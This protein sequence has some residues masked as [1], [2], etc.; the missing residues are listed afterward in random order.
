MSSSVVL[1]VLVL[2]GV[3]VGLT[4]R[5]SGSNSTGKGKAA[6]TPR[7]TSWGHAKF[8]NEVALPRPWWPQLD[9]IGI[10]LF[11]VKS[12]NPEALMGTSVSIYLDMR[13]LDEFDDLYG[14]DFNG[15]MT[16]K[17]DNGYSRLEMKPKYQRAKDKYGL[18]CRW[19]ATRKPTRGFETRKD[20]Y[21]MRLDVFA[22]TCP[23]PWDRPK[24]D[25]YFISWAFIRNRV[26]KGMTP[27]EI[28]VDVET[29]WEKD[30]AKREREAAKVASNP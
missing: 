26:K 14:L 17:D 8:N 2:L 1:A 13:N 21:S 3:L 25:P 7:S 4:I 18:V 11:D 16:V 20:V 28:A 12:K 6:K 9:R 15:G 30:R 5:G 10:E 27:E 22:L 23:W 24:E 29:K 19:D